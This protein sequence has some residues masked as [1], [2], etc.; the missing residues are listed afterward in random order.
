VTYNLP[1]EEF[2]VE[3][4]QI[5]G[6]PREVLDN[7]ELMELML[8]LLRADFE[9]T[10]TYEYRPDSPLR[11]PITAYGGL[12]DEVTRDKL[13]PWKDQ[14]SCSFALRMLPGDHFFLR[15]C[16]D[17]LVK[18]V[19]HDVHDHMARHRLNADAISKTGML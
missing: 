7:K 11:C 10:Q 13:I 16:Q 12:Q 8:P 14:T 2:I 4:E 17:Q 3:L 18:A 9:L 1:R 5:D 19:A 6:T 15:S